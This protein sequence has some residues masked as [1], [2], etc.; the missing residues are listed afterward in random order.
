[1]CESVRLS[2][3][4]QQEVNGSCWTS[5]LKMVH[6][7]MDCPGWYRKGAIEGACHRTSYM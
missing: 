1:M 4:L 2:F 6:I 7:S 3:C 5:S